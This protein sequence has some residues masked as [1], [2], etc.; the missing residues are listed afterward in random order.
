MAY[1]YGGEEFL[2]ILP[3]K[4]VES[5]VS[6]ADRLRRAV[7]NLGISHEKCPP[8]VVTIS[9]GVGALS[10]GELKSVD[11][12]LKE[13]DAALYRAKE[14]GRNRVASYEGPASLGPCAYSAAAVLARAPEDGPDAGGQ[15]VR[16]ERL[17]HVV[18]QAGLQAL[19]DIVL[20]LARGE[21]D[22]REL[23]Q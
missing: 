10:D 4:S 21:H 8:G 2:I 5:A 18:V 3:Q 20:A 22:D 7:E 16:R 13:A 11:A 12:L 15:L 14:S 1:R 17:R 23:G 19:Y 6:T 9:V